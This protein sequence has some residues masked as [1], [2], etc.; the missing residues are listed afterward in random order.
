MPTIQALQKQRTTT[1]QLSEVPTALPLKWLTKNH[2]GVKQLCIIK[3][4]LKALDQ[5]V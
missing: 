4:K 3:D 1:S 5:L 2:L